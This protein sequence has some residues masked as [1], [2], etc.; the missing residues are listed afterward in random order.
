[1]KEYES[2]LIDYAFE[3]FRDEGRDELHQW[4]IQQRCILQT[5]YNK[6]KFK[7]FCDEF[8]SIVG[9]VTGIYF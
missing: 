9:N 6:E 5:I 1:M 7:E 3:V 8:N 2:K 4:V